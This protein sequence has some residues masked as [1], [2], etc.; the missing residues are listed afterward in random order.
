MLKM[1]GKLY[2]YL[3]SYGLKELAGG[4]YVNFVLTHTHY[5]ISLG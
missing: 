4:Q 1:W 2:M 3:D 5:T